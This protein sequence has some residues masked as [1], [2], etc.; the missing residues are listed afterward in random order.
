LSNNLESLQNKEKIKTKLQYL[1][2]IDNNFTSLIIVLFKLFFSIFNILHA[3]SIDILC[4]IIVPM[5]LLGAE[6]PPALASS[7][8]KYQI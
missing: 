2:F 8:R 3:S 1:H 5:L 4:L 7:K 6:T